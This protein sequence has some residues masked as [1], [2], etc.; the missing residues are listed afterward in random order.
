MSA[1]NRWAGEAFRD[2][3]PVC[4]AWVL[5]S[6]LAGGCLLEDEPDTLAPSCPSPVVGDFDG[7]QPSVLPDEA[8]ACTSA[9]SEVLGACVSHEHG[10]TE[11]YGLH[12]ELEGVITEV[13][14]GPPPVP[15]HFPNGVGTL[16]VGATPPAPEDVRWVRLDVDGE[17]WVFALAAAGN[18]TALAVGQRVS[19][20]IEWQQA[21]FQL[22]YHLELRDESGLTLW[23]LVADNAPGPIERTPDCLTM[24]LGPAECL[25]EEP[26][27]Q[28]QHHSM[29]FDGALVSPGQQVII[30][31]LRFTNGASGFTYD[32]TCTDIPGGNRLLASTREG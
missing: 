17:S 9:L 15:C 31:D 6:M 29:A 11:E 19:A 30:D 22:S 27:W 26:C 25:S 13:G 8:P 32:A 4:G 7:Y 23:W 2:L 28:V 14:T 18:T 12:T 21:S 5:C 20:S 3:S 1:S 10:L 24:R 16:G